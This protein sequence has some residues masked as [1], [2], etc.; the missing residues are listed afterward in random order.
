MSVSK[1][2]YFGQ[3]HEECSTYIIFN[4]TRIENVKEENIHLPHAKG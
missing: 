2:R 1:I 3:T 4:I